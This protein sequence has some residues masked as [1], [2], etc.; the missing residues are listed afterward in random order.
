MKTTFIFGKLA[1]SALLA[2]AMVVPAHAAQWAE[3]LPETSWYDAA[4]LRTA[5][6]DT[7]DVYVDVWIKSLEPGQFVGPNAK[8]TIRKYQYKCGKKME[9]KMVQ[10]LA[11][12]QSEKA[13]ES[14]PAAGSKQGWSIV[15]P[16]SQDDFNATFFCTLAQ[17]RHLRPA[18]K[19]SR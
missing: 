10:Q 2:A 11:D 17:S 3:F 12:G 9:Y 13:I 18:P 14:A 16:D 15:T 19:A 8:F 7:N 6:A 4:T 1:A 5:K